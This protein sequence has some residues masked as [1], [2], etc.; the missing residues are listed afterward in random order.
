MSTTSSSSEIILDYDDLSSLSLDSSDRRIVEKYTKDSQTN[1]HFETSLNQLIPNSQKEQSVTTN[2]AHHQWETVDFSKIKINETISPIIDKTSN[3]DTTSD[4][5]IIL[6]AS[7]F[8]ERQD[9]IV[10][11]KN[12][13]TT[14]KTIH[15]KNELDNNSKE[16]DFSLQESKNPAENSIENPDLHSSANTENFDED[17]ENLSDLEKEEGIQLDFTPKKEAHAKE[18]QQTPKRSS[19]LVILDLPTRE[20]DVHKIEDNVIQQENYDYSNEKQQT[21]VLIKSNAQLSP[22][23]Q[24]KEDTCKISNEYHVEKNVDNNELNN[25]PCFK[26]EANREIIIKKPKKYRKKRKSIKEEKYR[27]PTSSNSVGIQTEQIENT[28]DFRKP[29]IYFSDCTPLVSCVMNEQEILQKT[30]INPQLIASNNIFKMQLGII[31]NIIQQNRQALSS[32]QEES[33]KNYKYTSF[34]DMK[35]RMK[36]K[37]NVNQ[38]IK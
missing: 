21:P 9:S 10:H 17:F 8:V 23:Q 12:M 5:E 7:Q 19:H 16:H 36:K 27:E 38:N 2:L 20:N 28:P 25:N 34:E 15:P 37:K 29:F 32:L 24:Q 33:Q 26:Y 30:M 14:H 4:G 35:K 22:L 31:Q 11:I 13:E 3:N 1:T 6:D 18:I